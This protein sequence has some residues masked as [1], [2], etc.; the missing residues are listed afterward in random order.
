MTKIMGIE[1]PGFNK[2]ELIKLNNG[3]YSVIVNE[4]IEFGQLDGF[5]T[6]VNK[7]NDVKVAYFGE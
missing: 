2:I 1:Q 3:Q 6:A 7:Y 5:E 4:V